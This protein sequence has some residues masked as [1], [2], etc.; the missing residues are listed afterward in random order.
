MRLRGCLI[1]LL[2]LACAPAQPQV[3]ARGAAPELGDGVEVPTPGHPGSAPIAPCGL[4]LESPSPHATEGDTVTF[5]ATCTEPGSERLRLEVVNLPRGAR[6]DAGGRFTWR[7]DGADGGR[8]T[9]TVAA[10]DPDRPHVPETETVTF[11]VADDPDAPGAVPPEPDRY[12]EEWGLPVVH[13][14]TTAPLSRDDEPAAFT[15]RGHRVTGEIKIRGQTSLAYP[16]NSFTLDFDSDELSVDEWEGPSRGHMVLTTTFDDNS[17]V[18]QKLV[19]DVW[20]AMADAQGAARLTPRTFFA[21]VYIDG[22]YHGLYLASDRIDDEFTRHMGFGGAGDLYKAVSHDANY[23]LLDSEGA[24]KLDLAAGWEKKEGADTDDFAPIASLTAFTGEADGRA[25]WTSGRDW[26][27][28]DEILDW[29]LLV[30]FTLA[31]DSAGKNAYLYRDEATGRFRYVPWD[32]NG[33]WG[34]NWYTRRKSP[35]TIR[36]FTESNHLFA[37]LSNHGGAA[38]ELGRRYRRLRDDGAPFDPAWLHDRL[39]RYAAVLGPSIDRDWARWGADYTS[40]ERWAPRRTE[41]DSW[42]DPSSE[43]AYLRAW[44]DARIEPMDAWAADVAPIGREADG[45]ADSGAP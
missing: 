16:K 43:D 29:Q 35:D 38:A 17:Y 42:T 2:G 5:T 22:I 28:I 4:M 27:D 32:F 44:I 13:I 7:T 9:L 39:D 34:Q 37:E 15:V 1:T 12:T 23:A 24:P 41:A 8:V 20:A 45:D 40:F 30:T 33:S 36:D 6:L 19:Y 31:E 18:R 21:V 26:L 14:E 3:S 10:T 11:W 25:L